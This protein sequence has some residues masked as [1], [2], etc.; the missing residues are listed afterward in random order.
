[1]NKFVIDAYAWIEYFNGTALGE[2]AKEIIENSDNFIYTSAITIAEL[3]SY[4]K[5]KKLDFKEAKKIL[6]SLSSFY[7]VNSELAEEAG[8]L[9]AE[10][11][12]KNRHFGLA[13]A[14]ILLTAKKLNA[15]VLTGDE[16]FREIKEAF[17]I[18]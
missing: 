9:H 3:S 14:F 6:S 11:K 10:I 2:K 12:S 15:K 17:L 16:D 18:K 5:R 1:M 4:F 13:D 8:L 7:P